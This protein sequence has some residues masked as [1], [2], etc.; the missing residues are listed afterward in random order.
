MGWLIDNMNALENYQN[1]DNVRQRQAREDAYND[2]QRARTRKEQAYSDN[3]RDV[4]IQTMTERMADLSKPTDTFDASK[5]LGITA[6]KDASM[7][8]AVTGSPD[9]A[10]A[11]NQAPVA[12]MVPAAPK[13]PTYADNLAQSYRDAAKVAL[14]GGNVAGFQAAADGFRKVKLGQDSAAIQ[15]YV[16]N[17]SDSDLSQL[18]G[19][20]SASPNN[21]YQAIY[22]PQSGF[23]T[24][25]LGDKQASLS[26]DELGRYFSAKHRISQG[27]PTAINDIAGINKELAERVASD[28]KLTTDVAHTN[29]TGAYYKSI[30]DTK[31]LQTQLQN[32]YRQAQVQN[33]ADRNAT[34]ANKRP[35]KMTINGEDVL[36]DPETGAIGKLV[37]GTESTPEQSHWFKPND[38]AKPAVPS[39]VEWSL[40]GNVL[41]GL[42]RQETSRAFV[43]RAPSPGVGNAIQGSINQAPPTN[44]LKEGVATSFGNGQIWA[45]QNGQPVRIK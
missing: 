8:P 18:M 22:D 42:P 6:S 14:A 19:K 43:N 25:K 38:P 3:A 4:G 9:E 32:Q 23:T 12:P 44:L 16:M 34:A 7:A 24:L 5:T 27:D 1:N 28:L 30:S 15:D 10:A 31:E 21:S 29:N 13:V 39:R 41:P 45:L 33:M 2:E 35:Q 20:V 37:P 26:R 40:D 36:L 17:A 11:P